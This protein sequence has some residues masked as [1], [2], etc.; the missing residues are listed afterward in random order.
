MA[1]ESLTAL[2]DAVRLHQLLTAAQWAELERFL[3]GGPGDM[4]ALARE[5][6]RRGWLTPYQV[7][8]LVQGRGQELIVG[9]YHLLEPLGE[10][11]MGQVL[12]ARH[13]IMKRVVALKLIRPERLA[14][15]EMVRR[16]HR[17]IELVARLAHPNVVTA[18]DAAQAE[19]MHFFVMEYV[20]GTDLAKLVKRQGPLPVP[21]AC[22][23]AHQAARGLQHIHEAGLVHRDIKPS[24]LILAVGGVVKILDLG[25]ARIGMQ[26]SSESTSLTH[27]GDVMGTPDYMAP[28]QAQESR[29]ADIRA[30]IYSLGCTLYYLLAGKPPFGGSTFAQKIARHLSAE[31]PPLE[32]ARSDLPPGLGA[33]VRKMLAKRPEDRYQAPAE[34]ADALVPFCPP[35][36]VAV[37][38]LSSE[39]TV[40]DVREVRPADEAPTSTDGSGSLTL[41]VAVP[42]A[43]A[44]RRRGRAVLV[45]AGGSAAVLALVVLALAWPRGSQVAETTVAEGRTTPAAT[46]KAPATGKDN[47][48]TQKE[49]GPTTKEVK[50]PVEP[51]P[52]LVR[53][54]E[55]HTGPVF[56][57]AVSADGTRALSG[58]KALGL[59]GE[60]ILWDLAT[61]KDL[62]HVPGFFFTSVAFTPG[63]QAAVL[64]AD[65]VR[66]VSLKTLKETRTFTDGLS[67]RLPQQAVLTADGKAVLYD[68]EDLTLRM[69]D[70]QTGEALGAFKGHSVEALGKFKGQIPEVSIACSP[71]GKWVLSGGLDK[72][73]LLWDRATGKEVRRQ[74]DPR[75]TFRSVAFS[76]DSKWAVTGRG[77]GLVLVWDVRKWVVLNNCF[78][79]Q[80]T[81]QAAIFTEDGRRVLSGGL[82]NSILLWDARTGLKL[83]EFSGHAKAV[84]SLALCPG[85]R[86]FV[87]ASLDGTVRLWRLPREQE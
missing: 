71:D 8:R 60:A 25:L 20:E 75:F 29:A 36:P 61:G 24:N 38:A 65:K 31:P 50:P 76:P 32:Q 47:V 66:V 72:R 83:H 23:V 58:G 79:H 37:P 73:L 28:E 18:Y 68:D 10:G 39:A 27:H 84:T 13:A 14:G 41:P 53:T 57:V 85:G 82:D 12:K 5:M 56:S 86:H 11:G 2:I 19:G 42:V 9:R 21:Q 3:Q 63:D 55:G 40:A 51:P 45:G 54:F 7:N 78:L 48:P 44:P 22:D 74:E 34:A 6:V 77:D 80:Q 49:K 30:D 26:E 46:R 4:R 35:P 67:R 59:G 62:K 43:A 17:E 70:L 16:F 1:I 87:S 69:C 52:G 81:V 33:V 64:A 15:D